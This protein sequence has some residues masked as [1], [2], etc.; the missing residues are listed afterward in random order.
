[1]LHDLA[2]GGGYM[3]HSNGQLDRKVWRHRERM[4]YKTTCSTASSDE[5]FW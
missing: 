5:G 2:N 4:S 3:L 1:M